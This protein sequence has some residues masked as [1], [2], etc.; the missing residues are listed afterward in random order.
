MTIVYEYKWLIGLLLA[1]GIY[2][3]FYH[4][5]NGTQKTLDLYRQVAYQL[6]LVAEKRLFSGQDKLNYVVNGMYTLLPD[7]LSY[8]VT[9]EELM[10]WIQ[11][12]YDDFVMDFLDDGELNDSNTI[13]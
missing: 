9:Q 7:K 2:T 4:K 12:L 8:F 3:Y 6:M 10:E 5:R 11:T 1:G 13:H